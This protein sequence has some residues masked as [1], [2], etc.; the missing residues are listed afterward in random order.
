MS[1]NEEKFP[2]A[3]TLDGAGEFNPF[4]AHN[5]A[6]H[7]CV[8]VGG[9]ATNTELGSN[10]NEKPQFINKS[11]H[12][13]KSS[14]NDTPDLKLKS[15]LSCS[16]IGL[17]SL[18][19]KPLELK[20]PLSCSS[21]GLSLP[22]TGSCP[23][24]IQP[25]HVDND[26]DKAGVAAYWRYQKAS[27]FSELFGGLRAALGQRVPPPLPYSMEHCGCHAYKSRDTPADLLTSLCFA[28]V[29]A[30]VH[31]S[32][33]KNLLTGKCWVIQGFFFAMY[34]R[35]SVNV[36]VFTS[37]EVGT[38][39]VEMRCMQ[40]DRGAC[41]KLCDYTKQYC[42]L[43][44]YTDNKWSPFQTSRRSVI[45][46]NKNTFA[47][48]LV[49]SQCHSGQLLM[50]GCV[51]SVLP[52]QE[53]IA[54]KQIDVAEA[55]ES[56]FEQDLEGKR[57][58]TSSELKPK[59]SVA[60]KGQCANVT[61]TSP[62]SVAHTP[63]SQ[64]LKLHLCKSFQPIPLPESIL[65]K[66]ASDPMDGIEMGK[67]ELESLIELQADTVY[68]D[69]KLNI[70]QDIASL[71]ATNPRAAKEFMSLCVKSCDNNGEI[72]ILDC[73]VALLER[74]DSDYYNNYDLQYCVLAAF[75]N[76]T[77][78]VQHDAVPLFSLQV[79]G[80]MAAVVRAATKFT[81]KRYGRHL[82]VH[83]VGVIA[84]F[85]CLQ[86]TASISCG[87][88]LSI[89]LPDYVGDKTLNRGTERVGNPTCWVSSSLH[90]RALHAAC[91]ELVS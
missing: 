2:G 17:P 28:M 71:I 30:D 63:P 14:Y 83:A 11:N 23:V 57:T 33:Q 51:Q 27:C 6:V 58:I 70:W 90:K 89:A 52:K 79:M 49:D 8:S 32:N 19:T 77:Q 80:P 9:L 84:W 38:L 88:A 55:N 46:K 20:S 65:K 24:A 4:A 72:N 54:H 1:Q 86:A 62:R 22:D 85:T 78:A 53:S 37:E 26:N 12:Q 13:P 50:R 48:P 47:Q 60:Q 82:R 73:I 39:L 34:H 87:A 91:E 81:D 16:P 36:S 25:T 69:G 59:N 7:T 42:R 68:R 61:A 29:Y 64:P 31:I 40:G 66:L 56:F 74:E 76:A 3:T 67:T 21:I 45:T 41:D 44:E 35:T 10:D 18:D 43:S 15:P 75:F 5:R